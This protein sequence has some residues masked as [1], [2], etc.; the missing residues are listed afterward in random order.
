MGA[1]LGRIRHRALQ[2]AILAACLLLSV[3]GIAVGAWVV[4]NLRSA[5]ARLPKIETALH[6][7]DEGRFAEAREIANHMLAD[8]KLEFEERGGP[9]FVLGAAAMHEA[10]E[11]WSPDQQRRLNL[12]A[13]RYLDEARDCGFPE[14]REVEGICLLASS[15]FHGGQYA[16]CIPHL[17]E[18]RRAS[19]KQRTEL[20]GLLAQACFREATPRLNEALKYNQQYL[21]DQKLKSGERG[22]ALLE[23]AQIQFLL[24]EFENASQTLDDIPHAK[25]LESGLAV[26]RARL[27]I[28]KGDVARAARGS[29]EDKA[30]DPATYY[31]EAAQLLK[32]VQKRV[33]AAD[34]AVREAQLLLGHCLFNLGDARAAETQFSRTRRL[35]MGT[36]E[37]IAAAIEEADLQRLDKRAET[38]LAGYLQILHE[39]GQPE[40]YRNPWLPLDRLRGR[41]EAAI[42][43]LRDAHEFDSAAEL[44]EALPPLFSLARTIELRGEVEQAWGKYLAKKAE[45]AP[46]AEGPKLAETARTKHREAGVAFAKLAEIRKAERDYPD[47]VW[48]SAQNFIAGQDY[49]HA[50]RMVKMYLADDSRK[51]RSEAL[52]ALGQ[53]YLALNQ[54][55]QAVPPLLECVENFR[56]HP[57]SYRARLIASQAYLEQHQLADA[58]AILIDNLENESLAPSSLEWRDSLFALGKI[59]HFEATELESL[60]RK[61]GVDSPY[62]DVVKVALKDLERS[63][64]VYQ[65][66][67][68]RL[69][70]AV[71]RYPDAPQAVEAQYLIAESHRQ[72]AKW[73]RKLRGATAIETTRAAYLRQAREE[74]TAAVAAYEPLLA[75][76]NERQEKGGLPALDTVIMRNCYFARADVLFDLEQFEDA[77][78]AYSSATN[79]YHD[80]PEAL[81]AFVQIASCYRRTNR[82]AEARGTLEQA[83]VVLRRIP[84]E[85]SFTQTTRYDRGEWTQLLNWLSSL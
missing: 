15:E 56:K 60:S 26:M 17:Q 77:I 67:I 68:D 21:A 47:D 25:G 78:A 81:E 14:G 23:R 73:P 46:V 30:T 79:R 5:D 66:A 37:A 6:Q 16:Q 20:T 36:V 34:S 50:I 69:S 76:L 48:R 64:H 12:V 13:A 39:F 84:A 72:A 42:E 83:K 33:G 35:N 1:A 11:A 4:V 8:N 41:F 28:Q 7:L 65:E 63:F 9:L 51:R 75:I 29:S 52:I 38:A 27:L 10:E 24:G 49:R 3:T 74:L 40:D 44:I 43:G 58:K 18:A 54:V 61:Q 62:P 31:E 45:Q 71:K 82:P 32:P 59:L 55:D 57:D 80:R 53:C 22:T 70:E 2:V 19:P 85:A